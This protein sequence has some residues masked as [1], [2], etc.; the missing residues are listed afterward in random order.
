MA[1][2]LFFH[3]RPQMCQL[4]QSLGNCLT[5][6]W[7]QLGK[8]VRMR[9]TNAHIAHVARQGSGVIWHR[10]LRCGGIMRVVTGDNVHEQ[11]RIPHIF[12]E[13]AGMVQRPGEGKIPWRLTRP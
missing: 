4:R 7:L 8:E 6:G 12:A 3:R 10:H 5:H 2:S 13:R 1:Q 9:H 11:G